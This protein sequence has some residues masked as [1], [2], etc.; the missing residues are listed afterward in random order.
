LSSLEVLLRLM[1]EG[2]KWEAGER[3]ALPPQR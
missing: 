1:C 2:D 3:P